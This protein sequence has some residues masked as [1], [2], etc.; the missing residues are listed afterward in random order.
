M[1]EPVYDLGVFESSTVIAPGGNE[2]D[3][4]VMMSAMAKKLSV[5][6]G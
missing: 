6:H 2:D 3:G 1:R 4:F 5:H